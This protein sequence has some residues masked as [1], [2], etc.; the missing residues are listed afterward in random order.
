MIPE[1]DPI[2]WPG[3]QSGQVM[4]DPLKKTNHS[5]SFWLSIT[6]IIFTIACALCADILPL[7]EYDHIDWDNPSALP[8]TRVEKSHTHTSGEQKQEQT[9]YL[10]G[11]DTLGRDILTRLIFGARISLT[12]GFAVPI[13]GLILGGAFGILAGFYRGRLETIIMATMDIIL[14]FPGIVLMLAITFY[15][16]PGIENLVI[17]LGILVIPAFSRMARANTLKFAQNEFVQAAKMLGQKDLQI[18]CC[19]ILP[20]ILIPMIA[21]ALMLVGYMIL[22]EGAL[23]FLGIGIPAPVPSWGGMI[24]DGREV[25]DQAP[26]ITLLPSFIMFLTVLSFNLVGD[27]LRNL[28]DTKEGHL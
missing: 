13:I 1:Y 20:N 25:L 10:L 8:G 17:A 6:W 24:A 16:G 27:Y 7:A 3:I 12:I 19:E 22:I 4:T 14:A 9:I 18:M 26:F 23:S 15:L 2:I 11:T 5:L 28:V 21:Y